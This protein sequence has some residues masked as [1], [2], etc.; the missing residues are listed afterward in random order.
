MFKIQKIKIPNTC[1]ILVGRDL[2]VVEIVKVSCIIQ[3]VMRKKLYK[4]LEKR[5]A[6]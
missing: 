6:D 5:I 1:I 2:K 4:K 3:K